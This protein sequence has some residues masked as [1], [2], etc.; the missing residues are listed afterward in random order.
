VYGTPTTGILNNAAFSSIQEHFSGLFGSSQ[1]AIHSTQRYQNPGGPMLALEYLRSRTTAEPPNPCGF[2][3][4]ELHIP[5]RIATKRT[6]DFQDTCMNVIGEDLCEEQ[7]AKLYTS[8][9]RLYMYLRY[10]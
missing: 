7:E 9:A 5:A 4:H 10:P 6:N 8:C 1:P 2:V 3:A